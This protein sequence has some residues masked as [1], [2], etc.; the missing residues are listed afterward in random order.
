[1]ATMETSAIRDL[2]NLQVYPVVK[3]SM[4]GRIIADLGLQDTLEGLLILDTMHIVTIRLL[5]IFGT[6]G[7]RA[8]S[9]TESLQ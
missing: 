8:M 3:K 1:M 6:V 4:V 2:R 7:F 9:I 5:Q